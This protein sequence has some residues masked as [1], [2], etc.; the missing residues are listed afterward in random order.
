MIYLVR[1][2]LHL[3]LEV[4]VLVSD[5]D[6]NLQDRGQCQDINLRDQGQGTKVQDQQQGSKNLP[7]GKALPRG[8]TSL[9]VG[10]LFNVL[11]HLGPIDSCQ[12]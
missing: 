7:W 4:S 12:S 5:Q 1:I 2:V 8:I 10:P 3:A 6:T 9:P 11:Q